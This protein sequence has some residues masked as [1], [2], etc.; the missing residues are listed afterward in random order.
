MVPKIEDY[1]PATFDFM[2][3]KA[4]WEDDECEC[5]TTIE[6]KLCE[7]GKADCEDCGD[8]LPFLVS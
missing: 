4:R 3:I 1:N 5:G 7:C 6:E 2:S 8:G